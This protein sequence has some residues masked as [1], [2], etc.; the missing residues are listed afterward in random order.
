MRTL[1]NV[2]AAP[3]RA[4]QPKKKAAKPFKLQPRD[5]DLAEYKVSMQRLAVAMRNL[6]RD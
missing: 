3:K 5:A 6:Y 2:D 1:S 4:N